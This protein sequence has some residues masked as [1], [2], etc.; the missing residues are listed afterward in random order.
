MSE[1]R[2]DSRPGTRSNEIVF[3]G[4]SPWKV[5]L[6]LLFLAFAA[7]VLA[8]AFAASEEFRTW[9]R[10]QPKPSRWAAGLSGGAATVLLICAAWM[11]MT[12]L[13]W[14]A[15]SPEGV[16]WLR[17]PRAR[18]RKWDQYVGVHR[19][20][21]EMTVFGED[22]RVGQYADVEFRKGKPLRISTHTIYGYEELIAEIQTTYADAMRAIFH[23]SG[24]HS[25]FGG[26]VVAT[27]GPLRLYP[28]GLEWGKKRY[29]W[30]EIQDYQVKV[31]YLRIQPFIGPEFLRRL[32]ELGDWAPAVAQ[33]DKHVGPR[34]AA[35]AAVATVASVQSPAPEAI[36]S[37]C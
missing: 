5:C 29:K 19:G 27:Y 35:K 23:A 14:V 34:L 33:L 26:P 11:W 37:P 20:S 3:P 4:R 1:S 2:F 17:G 28:E 22:V 7:G 18:H 6:Q 25:G 31:G 15:V 12:R 30:D 32:T 13:R 21:L 10:V 8:S 9:L 24:S 36:P 16:R